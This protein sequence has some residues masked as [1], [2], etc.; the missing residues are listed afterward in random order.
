[1]Q[2]STCQFGAKAK[3]CCT[4]ETC[5]AHTLV[6]PIFIDAQNAHATA[7][8]VTKSA[9]RKKKGKKKKKKKVTAV[10]CQC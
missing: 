9:Q 4:T 5:A 1:V 3:K 6:G 8:A 10:T 2:I 7:Q